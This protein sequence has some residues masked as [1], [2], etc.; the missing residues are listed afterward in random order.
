MDLLQAIILAF[1]EGLTEFLPVSSTGHLVV[2]ASLMN[3]AGNDFTKLFVVAI[4]LGAILSVMVLYF[5]R[6][7]AGPEIYLRLFIAFVPSVILG[8]LLNDTIDALLESPVS[9]AI[10]FV[11]GGLILLKVD[12]WFS[13]N[14]NSTQTEPTRLQSLRIGLFQCLAMF[15]GVSRS[16]ATITG[17]LVQ[18]LNR[19]T[20]AEFSFLL[21][22]PT[23][24]AATAYKMY[25]YLGMHG[26]L[27]SYEIKTLAVGNVVAFVVGLLAIKGFIEFLSSRGF[28]WFGWYRILTGLLILLIHFFIHPL[29]L[30]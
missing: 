15:P 21:A 22:V 29:Q 25:K 24:F 19:K 28:Q 13:S 17:G 6:F 12:H 1:V 16:A 4:Q 11:I 5:R 20:A 3:I 23:M 10:F 18:G 27:T 9:V 8:L 14:A 26:S 30:L 7:F 2:T